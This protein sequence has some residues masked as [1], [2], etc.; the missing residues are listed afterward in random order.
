MHASI[1]VV[2]T[3]DSAERFLKCLHQNELRNVANHLGL[4]GQN[5][6]TV[7]DLISHWL[8]QEEYN[9]SPYWER[10]AAALDHNGHREIALKIRKGSY[11]E[12]RLI[13]VLD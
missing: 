11:V 13:L 1:H 5:V 10:L 4:R 8:P 3:A 12:P 7:K 9:S 2:L 6:T